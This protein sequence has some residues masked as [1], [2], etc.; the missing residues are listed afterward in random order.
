MTAE[1]LRTYGEAYYRRQTPFGRHSSVVDDINETAHW[2]H[3]WLA[4]ADR[5]LL[6][7]EGHNRSVMDVGC[8]MG[9]LL[10]LLNE[11]GFRCYGLDRSTFILGQGSQVVN[12]QL[13]ACD[14]EHGVSLRLEFDLITCFEVL[15]HLE[16]PQHALAHMFGVLAPGG[17]LLAS[18]PFPNAQARRDPTHVS[19]YAPRTWR[20]LLDQAGFANVQAHPIWCAPGIWR[21]GRTW[22]R[23]FPAPSHLATSILL[24]GGKG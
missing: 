7:L 12:A 19:L 16:Y 4:Y 18:T 20:W 21:L 23:A 13:V 5:H 1:D 14:I 2:Y 8:G 6:P 3:G 24:V 17:T 10:T 11:R 22:S 9:A 15:E